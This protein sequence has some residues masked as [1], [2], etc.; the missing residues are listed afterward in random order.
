MKC[1]LKGFTQDSFSFILNKSLSLNK[2]FSP[3]KKLHSSFQT[4]SRLYFVMDLGLNLDVPPPKKMSEQ[5]K[6][7]YLN[8]EIMI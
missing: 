6:T 5:E 3:F 2:S 4:E 1:F 8:G 7:D